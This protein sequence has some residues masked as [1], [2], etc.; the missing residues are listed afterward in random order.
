MDQQEGLDNFLIC[1]N[2]MFVYCLWIAVAFNT[3]KS[4][5]FVC[6]GIRATAEESCLTVSVRF[7]ETLK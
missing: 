5:R 1:L 7:Y 2:M 4:E 3:S 6:M